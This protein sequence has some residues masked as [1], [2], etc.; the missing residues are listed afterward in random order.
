MN[1]DVIV[2]WPDSMDYPV[3]R[4]FLS[5]YRG[6]FNKIL[7]PIMKTNRAKSYKYVD[8]L[9]K[10]AFAEFNN[11]VQIEIIE[12][13]E[14]KGD[15]RSSAINAALDRSTATWVWF[16]EQDFFIL[17]P[18]A[19]FNRVLEGSKKSDFIVFRDDLRY[20]PACMF[21]K[22]ELID[23]TKRDFGIV[24]GESDH[25]GK[26]VDEAISIMSV[27][28][29]KPEI[30]AL[31]QL[32]LIKTRDYYHMDGLTHNYHLVQDGTKENIYK[33]AEF[34]AYNSYAR[35]VQVPQSEEFIK[36][37]FQT[38]FLLAPLSRFFLGGTL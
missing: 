2:T 7:I 4:Q 37:T 9:R 16:T 14:V 12:D 6:K 13:F 10:E 25:F 26:F 5:R 21:V 3:F 19:F 22:R 27:N 30:I 28:P 18:D 36:L 23:K 8:F 34:F 24:E 20:H 38:D 17:E 29:A 11:E 33:P 35:M 15:W 31:T 1:M 32:N